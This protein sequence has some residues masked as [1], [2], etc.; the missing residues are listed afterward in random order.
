MTDSTPGTEFTDGRE[1]CRIS[2]FLHRG[3]S[4]T[5]LPEAWEEGTSSVSKVMEALVPR[6]GSPIPWGLIV[7]AVNDGLSKNL[8]EIAEGSPAW[9]C[10]ADNADKI[11]LQVSQAPI[12]IDLAD[13]VE[14]LQQPTNE[15]GQITL[16]WI[17]ERLEAKKGVSIPDDVF[18]NAVQKAINDKIITLVD[19]LTND[20]YKVRVKQPSWMGLA[21][22]NLTEIEIQN[23]AERIGSLFGIAPELDF[24]FRISITVEGEPPSAEVLE[25]I[26]EELRKIT[27]QLKF[28]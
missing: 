8:F 24:K 4:Q 28:N 11:G 25:Q 7:T 2:F 3:L 19:P 22:S 20:L 1:L 15:S 27:D 21:E 10:G 14:L 6:K 5:T 9:P 13:L 18:H 17:K 16:G 12:T 26:N 23:L